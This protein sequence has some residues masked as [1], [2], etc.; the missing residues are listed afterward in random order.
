MG[1]VFIYELRYPGIR[2]V[3]LD[4]DAAHALTSLLGLMERGV[5]E[6]AVSLHFFEQAHSDMSQNRPPPPSPDE[7][8][9]Q[10]AIEQAV[11]GQLLDQLPADLTPEQRWATQDRVRDEARQEMKRQAWRAGEWPDSYKHNIPFLYAKAFLYA[12]DAVAQALATM[13]REPWAPE[14]ING[15]AADWQTA[16]PT[17]R[18]VRNTSQHEDERVLGRRPGNQQIELQPINNG[19]IHAPGGGVTVL[20]NLNGN[21]FGCTMA[22]GHFGEVEV[23]NATLEAVGALAQRSISAFSWEGPGRFAPY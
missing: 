17:V 14:G 21:R 19:M 23:S 20:S 6:A 3:G 11:E 8:Q 5:A 1:R 7:W 16:F 4:D 13:A 12:V 22:D 2:P 15:I 9:R 10:A 18:S